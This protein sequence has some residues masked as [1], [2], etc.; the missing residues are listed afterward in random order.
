MNH[1]QH[2]APRTVPFAD[3]YDRVH[4]PLAAEM[5]AWLNLAPGSRILDAGCGPGVMVARFAEAVGPGGHVA[6]LDLDPDVVGQAR[7]HLSFLPP[8][9]IGLHQGDFLALPFDD[10]SFDLAWASYVLHH[11]PDPVAAIAEL[12]RVTKL[13]GRVVVREGGVPLRWLPFDLGIGAPGLGD[14]LRVAQNRW[15]ADHRYERPVAQPY[16]AGWLQALRDG[17]CSRV[18]ARTFWLER[19]APLSDDERDY[20]LGSLTLWLDDSERSAYLDPD[21]LRTIRALADPTSPHYALRRDDVHVLAAVS[22]YVG[23]V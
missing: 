14:R 16:P 11:V 19:L 4:A 10:N 20:L 3:G 8:E 1:S 9:R 23:G 2:C 18:T 5:L 17:G 7:A 22:L 13:G 6:G 15:F 21:D 12:R